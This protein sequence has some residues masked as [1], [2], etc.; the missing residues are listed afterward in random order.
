MRGEKTEYRTMTTDSTTTD[1][2]LFRKTRLE[3]S[4]SG[5]K[6]VLRSFRL[7]RTISRQK[8]FSQYKIKPP[9]MGGL[10]G[11]DKRQKF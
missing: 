5:G 10:R 2:R 9:P 4:P 8:T 6:G 1:K 11:A 3:L 7:A